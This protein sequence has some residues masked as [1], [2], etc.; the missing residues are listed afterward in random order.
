MG[1]ISRRGFVGSGVAAAIAARIGWAAAV[2]APPIGLQLYSVGAELQRDVPGVLKQLKAIGY[3]RVET[4]GYAGLTAKAF[5]AQLDTAGLI[6]HSVHVPLGDKPSGPIFDEA[7]VIGAAY[8]VSSS[9]HAIKK[10]NGDYTADD[11]RAMAEY[12]DGLGRDAQKAGLR[13]AYHNHNFEFRKLADGRMGYEVLLEHTDPAL[14]SFELDCG[15]AV[16]AGA[17]P[18]ALFAKYP[19]RFRMLHI[20]DFLVQKTPITSLAKDVRPDGKE[21]GAGNIGYGPILTAA[22]RAGIFEYY[23]EQEPPFN[24]LPAME[25]V[26]VDFDYLRGLEQQLGWVR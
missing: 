13:Y 26:K 19:K 1:L 14:V 10:S 15:W 16:V 4:A 5:R 24:H 7:G 21:L 8:A 2:K 12:A 11:Y 9:L 20:K 25:A 22:A 3:E 17:D 18:V 23:I 6:C